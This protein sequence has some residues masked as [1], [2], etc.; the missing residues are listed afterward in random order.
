MFIGCAQSIGDIPETFKVIALDDKCN[1]IA[2]TDMVNKQFSQSLN[3]GDNFVYPRFYKHIKI[4]N[5]LYTVKN[6]VKTGDEIGYNEKYYRYYLK[7][8]FN[9]LSFK[10]F[11]NGTL[12]TQYN[13]GPLKIS[14]SDLYE[15]T[16]QK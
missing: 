11:Y 13:N 1:T 3:E 6:T 8:S 14:F 16:V 9:Y 4:N 15:E 5:V 2:D 7:S 12:I 10:D